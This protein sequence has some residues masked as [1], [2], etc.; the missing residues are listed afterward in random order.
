MNDNWKKGWR[1]QALG[2][3]FRVLGICLFCGAFAGGISHPHAAWGLMGVA[4]FA[5]V[6]V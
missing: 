2:I 3:G 4:G 6:M 1:G 5:M